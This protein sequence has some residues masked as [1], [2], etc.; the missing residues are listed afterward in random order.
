MWTIK[1]YAAGSWPHR[2]ESPTFYKWGGGYICHLLQAAY[3]L[4]FLCLLHFD[5]VLKIQAQDIHLI[6]ETCIAFSLPFCKTDQFG[7]KV[8]FSSLKLS[9]F[10]D[11]KPLILHAL[12]DREAHLCSICTL[13]EWITEA[14]ISNGY[15]FHKFASGD[16]IAAA[17]ILWYSHHSSES[18]SILN[19]YTQTSDQFLELFRNNLLDICIE[20]HPYGNHSFHHGGCQYLVSKCRWPIWRI[21][22]WGGMERWVYQLDYCQVS[23]LLE[24]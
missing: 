16:C 15:I 19:Q 22:E 7:G 24:W 23:Y 3:T 9:K 2:Q 14:K 6:S 8:L 11:I 12:P 17:M 1:D 20:P 5:E 21:C 13:G 4:A 10:S 18:C